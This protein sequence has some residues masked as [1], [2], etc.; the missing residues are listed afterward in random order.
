[1][2]NWGWRRG[3]R[4][5]YAGCVVLPLL[6]SFRCGNRVPSSFGDGAPGAAPRISRRHADHSCTNRIA[7]DIADR[8]E[9]MELVERAREEAVLPQ[10]S[11][12]TMAFVDVACVEVVRAADALGERVVARGGG[13]D[14]DVMVIRQ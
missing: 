8:V 5:L 6:N 7:F 1:M 3:G 2:Q 10:V 13:D 4:A 11:A 12:A 9:K 14:V